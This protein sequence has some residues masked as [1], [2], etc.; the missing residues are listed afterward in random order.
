MLKR[1]EKTGKKEAIFETGYGPSG[2]PHIGTFGEVVRTSMVRHA[3][4]LLTKDEIPTKIICFSDD[5]D[6]LRKVPTNVPNQ[7]RM[8]EY[9]GKP[10]TKVP[11]PFSDE[12][13][14]FAHHNNARLRKF[15]DA[16][17]FEYQFAS[18]TDYYTSGQLDAAL[19]RMLEV[20]DDV[21]KVI[22]PTLGEERQKNIFAISAHLPA[23]RD[24]VA[25]AH[26]R[27][28]C[29]KGHRDLCRP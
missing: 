18:A 9:L 10:L 11:D 28:R 3:F 15:L 16:F 13:P 2:L 19:L 21:M 29:G 6:G 14:S 12:H 5:M 24:C 20:Y 22:L 26:D 7:E 17:G 8:A 25:S 23:H 4:R 1:V 27:P